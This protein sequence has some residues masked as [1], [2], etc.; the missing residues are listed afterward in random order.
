MA[1]CAPDCGACCDPV[2]LSFP[3]E[4]MD[5][6]SA[7]FAREHWTEIPDHPKPPG[8]ASVVRCDAFD[9]AT[10]KCTA[11]AVRPPICSGFPW[12]GDP[13]DRARQLS[14]ACTFQADVRTVL[15]LTVVSGG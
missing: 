3:L 7:P 8:I 15:P 14:P 12:Y 11:Y 5:G 1:R 2:L 13:P 9:S 10:R 4:S 6:P